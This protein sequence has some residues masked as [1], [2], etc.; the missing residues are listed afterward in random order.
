MLPEWPAVLSEWSAWLLC[1]PAAPRRWPAALLQHAVCY[2]K[3][4]N[5]GAAS[6][7][8]AVAGCAV[9]VARVAAVS[10]CSKAGQGRVYQL[11]Q[12]DS[13]PSLAL[14]EP[15]LDEFLHVLMLSEIHHASS[16][17][18]YDST[19]EY[20]PYFFATDAL[21]SF[22][23]H[24]D[25]QVLAQEQSYL[26]NPKLFSK[27]G[28]QKS[29]PW[30]PSLLL[31]VWDSACLKRQ[32]ADLLWSRKIRKTQV[33]LSRQIFDYLFLQSQVL[34]PSGDLLAIL[35]SCKLEQEAGQRYPYLITFLETKILPAPPE[36]DSDPAQRASEGDVA[37]PQWWDALSDDDRTYAF[38]AAHWAICNTSTLVVDQQTV[39]KKLHHESQNFWTE[40]FAG[41]FQGAH[42][43]CLHAMPSLLS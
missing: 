15:L 3:R 33:E 29:L 25:S 34:G 37:F 30:R 4:T 2:G 24:Y 23:S 7:A 21:D 12:R 35:K 39:M 17:G 9:G 36:A 22:M 6:C 26:R 16:C 10:M 32:N 5:R 18:D 20:I 42:Q 41:R 40:A 38:L 1:W 27:A 28:K 19:R 13:Q 11:K 14:P 43:A 31:H 8:A